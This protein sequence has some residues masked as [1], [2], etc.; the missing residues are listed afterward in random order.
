MKIQFHN[1]LFL[2]LLFN[3]N[4]RSINLIM[5]WTAFEWK[6]FY[7]WNSSKIK[8]WQKKKSTSKEKLWVKPG[9]DLEISQVKGGFS[10]TFWKFGDLFLNPLLC[11]TL[12][13]F[14]CEFNKEDCPPGRLESSTHLAVMPARSFDLWFQVQGIR[15]SSKAS[16]H[17]RQSYTLLFYPFPHK[18][19]SRRYYPRRSL[20]RGLRRRPIQLLLS[21]CTR[22]MAHPPYKNFETVNSLEKIF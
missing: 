6:I 13:C 12:N 5:D 16:I 15:Y 8:C 21:L 3:Y 9:A 2:K 14:R 7:S 10:K 20:G 17:H 19:R 18:L 22:H 1:I 11:K 4:K